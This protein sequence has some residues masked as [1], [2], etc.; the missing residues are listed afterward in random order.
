MRRKVLTG[1]A[2]CAMALAD[3]IA[4]AAA[5]PVLPLREQAAV[6]DADLKTRLDT[7][8]PRLMREQHA[9][10]WVLVA[11]EYAEDPVVATMLDARSLHARRRTILIFFDPGGGKPLE[12]LTVSRYGLAGLFAPVWDP[13]KEPDQWRAFAAIVAARNP[14]K[15]VVDVSPLTAFGDGL[16][17]SQYE[18]LAGSLSPAL[19]SRIV[20]SE[21]LAVGWLETR[22]P[23]QLARYP[24]IV[25]IAHSIIAEAFSRKVITPGVTTTEDVQWWM[26]ERIRTLGFDTWFHPSIDSFRKGAPEPLEGATVIE[27]GDMLWCDFGITYLRLNTDTQQLAYVL[28]P[29]ETAAP[30]GLRAGLAAAN[31]LQDMLTSRFR[32][33]VTGNTLLAETRADAISKGL[34]PSIYSHPLGYHGHAAGSSIGYWDNQGPSP[35]GEH[36]LVADTAFSIELNTE[37]AVPEWGGQTIPFRLE[38]DGWFDG[39]AF[40]W[41]DGRETEFYLIR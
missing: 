15:I 7:I 8:V 27:P 16:T 29:G 3:T 22:S 10:M 9:D 19:R 23:D 37:A 41:L 36:P 5:P 12:R 31:K 21:A 13:S 33:G 30:A 26:R 20:E 34:K 40:H 2:V 24:G 35:T 17:H 4:A 32:L 38:E 14:H 1:L 39:K 11:R 6:I 25:A 18:A 28:R